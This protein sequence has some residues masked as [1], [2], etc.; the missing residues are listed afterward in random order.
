MGVAAALIRELRAGL[1]SEEV[2]AAMTAVAEEHGCELPA[3]VIVSH[4]AQSA[5]GHESGLRRDPG[6]RAG[7]RRHLAARPRLA[8]L[9]RHDPH[10]RRGRRRAAAGAGRV[11]EVDEG[12]AGPRLRRHPRRRQRPRCCSSAPPSRTS[13]PGQPTQLTKEPGTM[14]EDGYYHSLGHGVGLEVH[15]RPVHR[16]ARR[17]AASRATS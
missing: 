1:T 17:R 4:G 2:R 3:E 7:D 14:L 11:L 8:L 13:R 12:L 10:V 15:E 9:R 6:G 5:L 16:P